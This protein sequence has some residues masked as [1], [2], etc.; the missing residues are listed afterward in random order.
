MENTQKPGLW[1]RF[2]SMDRENRS[3]V[4][5]YS[6]IVVLLIL[7]TLLITPNFISPTFLTQQLRLASFLGIIAAGQMAVILTGNIDLSIPWTITL[8][9]VLATSIAAGQNDRLLLG[10]GAAIGVGAVVGLVNG[11]GVA[12]LRIPAMV[13]TLGLNAV[14]KGIT[15]V[16]TGS[17]PQFQ[18]TPDIL[19]WAATEVIFGFLPVA[20]VIWALVSLMQYLVLSRSGL[21]R[22]TYAVGNNEIAAYLSGVKT[23][24]V[25]VMVFVLSGALNALAGLLL[26]GNAG[27][28]FN[29]MGDPFLL[30]AIAAVVVGGTSILG[31]SGKYVG[32]IAGV[33]IVRLLD[34]ALNIVQ[35][36]PAAKDIT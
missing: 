3:V 10:A 17:A 9:A 8:S 21:G 20:V 4:I 32:T 36:P 7:G 15:V 13:L 31:G 16:Y 34:G 25:L 23:P 22:K 27:R 30:P 29:E 14:L 19:S 26:A 5:S 2:A 33:I 11:I 28:S 1:T 24:R 6:M 18:Q 35:V 12:Y